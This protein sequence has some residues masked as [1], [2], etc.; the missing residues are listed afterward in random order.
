M[1][2]PKLR[3]IAVIQARM[4]S[5]RLPGKVL[6][7]IGDRTLL[8][9]Q[10]QRLKLSKKIHQVVVATSTAHSDDA[11]ESWGTRNNV[12][13]FRGPEADVL[14]RVTECLKAYHADIHV[15]ITGDCPFVDPRLIDD[16]VRRLETSPDTTQWV[17][18]SHKTTFPPGTEISIHRTTSVIDVDHLLHKDSYLREHVHAALVRFIGRE[19]GTEVEADYEMHFP[20]FYLEVD[21]PADL[22]VAKR[23]LSAFHL[24]GISYPSTTELVAFGRSHPE[25]VALNKNQF[26]RWKKF[27]GE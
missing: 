25:I 13:V 21:Y 7:K 20:D 8:D 3:V 4:A 15:E 9:W 19:H 17:T 11:I 26:R 12:K 22:E 23:I 5:T 16:F 1:V 27:R 18:S 10:I 14:R 2:S 6:T 24:K